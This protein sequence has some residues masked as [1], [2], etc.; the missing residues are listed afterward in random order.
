ML[1]DHCRAE[2]RDEGEI[3]R[4]LHIMWGPETSDGE[5]LDTIDAYAAVGMQVFVFSMRPPYDA[6]RLKP[7]ATL[8]ESRA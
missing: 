7:L 4:S 2:G 5:I 1:I 3:R 6:D 8:L